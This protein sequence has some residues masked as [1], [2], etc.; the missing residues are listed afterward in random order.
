MP[1][2]SVFLK[3][4]TALKKK[5]NAHN[6]YYYILDDPQISDA[7]F[8]KLFRELQ[9]LEEQYPEFITQDSPTQRI[10]STP[11][12]SF[13]RVEHSVAMLS[14]DN[15]FSEEEVFAFNK[16]I[17]DR[18][19]SNKEIEYACEPKLD[20]IAVSLT[21]QQ[22][23]LIRAATRGDG[24]IGEDITL[25]SRTILSIPLQLYGSNYPDTLEVR[26]EIYMP[27]K[28]FQLLNQRLQQAGEKTFVNPRNAAAGS[29]RQLDPKITAQRALAFFT[30]SVGAFQKGQLADTHTAI[31]QKFEQWGLP[32]CPQTACVQGIK[33]CLNYYHKMGKQR[34][35][36]PY[37]IDGVVYKVNILKLQLRLGFISRAPRWALAH[38][39]P[40]Q[41]ELSRVLDIEFQVGRTG[42][43]TPVARLEPVFVGGATVS[44][45][46]LHNMDEVHRKDVRI[47]DSVT[48]RRAGDV[49]PEVVCVIKEKRPANTQPLQL[50]K[51]CPV[52]GSEVTKLASES[53]ARC[54]G[55]LYCLAQLKQAIKHF[56]S[57]KAMNIEGL[58]DRIIDQLVEKALIKNVADLYTL[59]TT[60][61]ANLERLGEKSAR[62]L[63]NAIEASKKT[64]F[65]RFLYAL[66]IRDVGISTALNLAQHFQQLQPLMQ[67]DAAYLQSLSDIGPVVAMHIKKFFEQPH[68]K[69]I[70]KRLLADGI[71]WPTSTPSNKLTPLT[72]KTFVLTGKLHNLSREEVTHQLQALGAKVSNSVSKKTDYL[73]VGIDP[74]SKLIQAKKFGV[75]C[76][77]LEELQ[78]LLKDPLE[79][80]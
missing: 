64:H 20:G 80:I 28:A 75:N 6:Y 43:L 49:I 7:N 22:G 33:A 76:L 50:P 29:L 60:Q 32:R 59:T 11:L 73:V 13:N 66:G 12:T 16:R 56:A 1:K 17:Q 79:K 24:N 9:S 3:K 71:Q 14:L 30:H 55:G 34:A 45:A 36:L 62:K 61:L 54:N 51:N 19:G 77:T 65:S 58:G 57:R 69:K 18:L 53:V 8:D 38:K 42:A 2:S 52:C 35:H 46:T 37:E 21:Y 48:V 27:K 25:N 31:L 10:G 26:G 40:A 72:G 44:N 5:I 41:E 4:I 39:F 68:N 70:I 47:G 67:A 74:G 63:Y 78:T 23:K 15:A